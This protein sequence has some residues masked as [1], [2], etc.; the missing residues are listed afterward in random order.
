M[1]EQGAV[2]FI[3]THPTP[4]KKGGLASKG[5]LSCGDVMPSVSDIL[6]RVL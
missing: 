6:P 2:R 1:I 5:P 3:G 4:M